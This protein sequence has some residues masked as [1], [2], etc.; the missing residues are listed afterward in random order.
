MDKRYFSGNGVDQILAQESAGGSVLWALTDQLGTVN[1]WVNNSG[2]VANHVRYDSFG[3]VVSQSNSAF[4]SRYGF[5]GREFDAETGL[6]Y[7]RSRYYNPGMGRF[8]GEDSVGFG[9]G[10][11][12]LY[13]YVGN[14]PVNGVDPS[15]TTSFPLQVL[16]Q[17]S[18][19]GSENRQ[20]YTGYPPAENYNDALIRATKLLIDW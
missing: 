15:G 6:Y 14:S 9:G 5:T 8:I 2:S 16:L 13:R 19:R 10:D 20:V 1:D 18:Q 17:L 4:G 7:Y 11:A 12:N 3:G